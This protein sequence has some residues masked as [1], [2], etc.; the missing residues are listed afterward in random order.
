MSGAPLMSMPPGGGP[1]P[2][3]VPG[4]AQTPLATGRPG[5]P[6][7][8]P[9]G[10]EPRTASVGA[11]GSAMPNAPAMA[12]MPPGMPAGSGLPP[13]MAGGMPAMPP[14][15]IQKL[16]LEPT[17]Q[18]TNILG[19]SCQ[20]F[21]IKQRGQTMEV[22]ATDQLLPYQPYLRAQPHRLGPRLLEEQWAELVTALKLFPMQGS[23]RSD[24]G[25]ERFRFEV[26]SISPGKIEEPNDALFEA[27]QDYHETEP[28][29][30]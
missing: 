25:R 4:T 13:G 9:A 16:E 1:Q 30:F 24:S 7:G 29:P 22:W 11:S 8:M 3:T 6:G 12:Q 10:I 28:R 2:G 18:T 20:Q 14:M 15:M 23:L 19:Y 17:G 5:P 26:T 27:P 21:E